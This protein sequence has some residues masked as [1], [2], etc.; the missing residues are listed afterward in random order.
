MLSYSDYVPVYVYCVSIVIL[1]IVSTYVTKKNFCKTHWA[2]LVCKKFYQI[3][4]TVKN[5][6]CLYLGHK[7]LTQY[8]LQC[9]LHGQKVQ[10]GYK[11]D[12]KIIAHKYLL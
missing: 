3:H 5:C 7:I 11:Y 2:I 1:L 6:V 10:C 8:H 9:T 4:T 12:S